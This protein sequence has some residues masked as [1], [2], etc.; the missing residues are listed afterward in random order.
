MDKEYLSGMKT[1][2][3]DC[4]KYG[5]DWVVSI[6]VKVNYSTL[7]CE[8]DKGYFDTVELMAKHDNEKENPLKS[9]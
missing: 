8:Y 3:E 6:T 1:A 2:I 7:E 5:F 9:R 4:E